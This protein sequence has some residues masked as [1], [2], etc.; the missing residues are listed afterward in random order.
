MEKEQIRKYGQ[1]LGVDAVGFVALEDYKSPKS[2]DPKSYLPKAK[3][4]IVLAHRMIDGALDSKNPRFN[5]AGRMAVMDTSKSHLYLMARFIE[6]RTGKKTS[7]VLSSYPLDMEAPT[8][9]LV[10]DISLRH[11]AVASGLG[12]FG[13]HNLVIHPRFGSRLSFTGLLTEL[14]LSSDEPL[15]EELCNDCGLCVD[16]CPGKALDKEGRTEEL[17]CLRASQPY[18]DTGHDRLSAEIRRENAGGT[19]GPPQGPAAHEPLS[20]ILHRVPVHLLQLHRRLPHRR[21][22]LKSER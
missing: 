12:V 1:D 16:A 4:I 21:D 2:P 8:L 9:G 5:I 15:K 11:A 6:G 22:V 13:R 14:P 19:A 20:G 3:S 7:P 17:K 18:G 10:G